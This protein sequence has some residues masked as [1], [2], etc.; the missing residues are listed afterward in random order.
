M[1]IPDTPSDTESVNPQPGASNNPRKNRMGLPLGTEHTTNQRIRVHLPTEST[2]FQVTNIDPKENG[3]V[4]VRIPSQELGDAIMSEL[5]G[6]WDWPSQPDH[7]AVN[8]T[9]DDD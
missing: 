3:E 1:A 5:E 9:D 2:G 7:E 4:I 6:N 8:N